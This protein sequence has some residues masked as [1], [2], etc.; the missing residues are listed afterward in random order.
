M[1]KLFLK[2][3][4]LG[5]KSF[6]AENRNWLLCL[7]TM[8][9]TPLVVISIKVFV[10]TFWQSPDSLWLLICIIA[11]VLAFVLLANY[12]HFKEA[13]KCSKENNISF[14]D[15]WNATNP[16]NDADF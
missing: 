1:F 9:A 3:L 11:Y 12:L 7:I 5:V 6:Y 15:A 14:E 2:S 8:F 16:S 10:N 4:W 13:Q